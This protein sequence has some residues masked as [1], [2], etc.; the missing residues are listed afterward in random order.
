MGSTLG[1]VFSRFPQSFTA[2]RCTAPAGPRGQ[3]PRKQTGFDDPTGGCA[4]LTGAC[5]RRSL[6]AAGGVRSEK[7]PLADRR[8]G[9]RRV[10]E[11]R[12]LSLERRDTARGE[13]ATETPHH[14][15]PHAIGQTASPTPL[16]HLPRPACPAEPALPAGPGAQ[17]GAAR[18]QGRRRHRAAGPAPPSLES[19]QA[20]GPDPGELPPG[21]A[22][23]PSASPCPAVRGLP[24]SAMVSGWRPHAGGRQPSLR[25][26]EPRRLPAVSAQIL[27]HRHPDAPPGSGGSVR[28]TCAS[29]AGPPGAGRGEGCERR[30]PEVQATV[31]RAAAESAS[32]PAPEPAPPRRPPGSRAQRPALALILRPDTR[33]PTRQTHSERIVLYHHHRPVFLGTLENNVTVPGD[34][35]H[36]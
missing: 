25:D 14:T 9:L 17:M 33:I 22:H 16:G 23:A 30:A 4:P 13:T 10:S 5:E 20:R 8:T 18:P 7:V 28:S 11:R 15:T 24:L 29:S 32:H 12:L 6:W 1:V 19:L 34:R 3:Q 2:G 27:W 26:T 35:A 21:G 36:R 31:Q